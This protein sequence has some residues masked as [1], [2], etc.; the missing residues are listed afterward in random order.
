MKTEQGISVLEVMVALAIGAMLALVALPNLQRYMALRD[1]QQT[2]R[3]LGADL[4]LTQQYA[5][6]Q[7]ETFRLAYVAASAQYQLSR[8]SDGTVVKLVAVPS[9]VTI[10]STFPSAQADF[11]SAGAPAQSGMFCLTE[12]TATLKVDVLP[13]TGR[14]QITETTPCP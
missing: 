6:T 2:A 11:S 1:L 3:F 9:T 12:G 5:V 7:G 8:L 14:V 10:T 4:R 13:A